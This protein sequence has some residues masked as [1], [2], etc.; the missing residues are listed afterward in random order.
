MVNFSAAKKPEAIS[1]TTGWVLF[2]GPGGKVSDETEQ[3]AAW[4]SQS[5]LRL[6]LESTSSRETQNTAEAGSVIAVA[7]PESTPDLRTPRL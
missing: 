1:T 3:R 5:A 7:A 2:Q 6:S 4:R